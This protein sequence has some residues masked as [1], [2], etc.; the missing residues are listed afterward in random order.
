[1]NVEQM[2]TTAEMSTLVLTTKFS[3]A[4]RGCYSV[5]AAFLL[6]NL[7]HS[8]HGDFKVVVS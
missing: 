4:L 6:T 3:F 7:S 5:K 1:M 2:K 8:I